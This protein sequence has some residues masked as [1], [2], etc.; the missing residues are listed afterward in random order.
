MECGRVEATGRAE[1]VTGNMSCKLKIHIFGNVM[2]CQWVSFPD[3]SRARH[4]HCQCH[5]ISFCKFI[6]EEEEKKRVLVIQ[7]F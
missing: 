6:E 3:V 5:N 2:L 4:I 1:E 7:T